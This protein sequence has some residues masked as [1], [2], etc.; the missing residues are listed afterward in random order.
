MTYHPTRS[1][2][3]MGSQNPIFR[4][5]PSGGEAYRRAG[6]S[7]F[8]VRRALLPPRGTCVLRVVRRKNG[9][10]FWNPFLPWHT[11][12]LRYIQL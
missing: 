12:C 6:T 8:A 3:R 7:A 1:F 11:G 5:S 9:L 4:F 2:S 10:S